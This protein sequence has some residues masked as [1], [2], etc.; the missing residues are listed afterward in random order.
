MYHFCKEYGWT[1]EEFYAQ[2][3]YEVRALGVIME[4]VY[5]HKESEQK[6]QGAKM[7]HASP[8][9]RIGRRR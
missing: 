2:P 9:R 1:I 5:K 3:Y 8:T 6:K 7:K 4:E